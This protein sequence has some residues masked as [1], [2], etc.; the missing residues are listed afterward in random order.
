VVLEARPNEGYYLAEWRL[1]YK[2]LGNDT[3]IEV[4]L[5]A[6]HTI[7]AVFRPKPKYRVIVVYVFGTR[8]QQFST[9]LSGRENYLCGSF[10]RFM[11]ITRLTISIVTGR[12][13]PKVS[14]R[15]LSIPLL[16]LRECMC[17][18]ESS[19][20]FEGI[21]LLV[22]SNVVGFNYTVWVNGSE[23]GGV[24][25]GSVRYVF[26]DSVMVGFEAIDMFRLMILIVISLLGIGLTLAVLL[27]GGVMA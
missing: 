10:L 9:T 25:N 20:G 21:A 14:L 19:G 12:F 15:E 17:L 8:R 11:V 4:T 24:F 18:N 3:M 26:N 1:D 13:T 27:C 23:Y 22:E 2:V 6:S 5:N 16:F 7:V